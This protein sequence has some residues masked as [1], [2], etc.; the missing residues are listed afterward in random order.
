MPW[1]LA[2]PLR[3]GG[4]QLQFARRHAVAMQ[5][6]LDVA[7]TGQSPGIEHAHGTPPRWPGR[8]LWAVLVSE[9]G[10]IIRYQLR[11]SEASEGE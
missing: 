9:V 11:P 10:N 3:N 2:A 4:R 7:G 6:R 8:A 1:P 5:R